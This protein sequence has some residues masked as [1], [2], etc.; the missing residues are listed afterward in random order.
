MIYFSRWSLFCAILLGSLLILLFH[1]GICREKI[2]FKKA[3]I[4]YFVL[5]FFIFL[6]IVLPIDSDAFIVLRSK[7]VLTV[8]SN[9]WKIQV[10]KRI[11]I[12]MAFY[13]IW[14][15]GAII[16]LCGWCMVLKRD[17]RKLRELKM[18]SNPISNEYS[19]IAKRVGLN[20]SRIFVSD[21]IG[22]VVTVGIRDYMILLPELD[23]SENDMINILSHEASHVE[24]ADI[25][26]RMVLH[27]FCCLFWWNPIFKLLESDYAILME[28]RCDENAVKHCSL[29]EKIDYVETLKKWR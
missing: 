12:G 18:N 9:L 5:L 17:I 7:Y 23:Y 16:S 8:M 20:P 28:Y 11:T 25:L 3:I 24:H 10:Y 4:P 27:V 19:Y 13:A 14:G 6:R 1:F 21:K 2:A 15:S 29:A 22:E 26:I